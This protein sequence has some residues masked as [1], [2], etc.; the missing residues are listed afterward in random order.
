MC[1]KNGSL[2]LDRYHMRLV[3][4]DDMGYLLVSLTLEDKM[5]SEIARFLNN[6]NLFH[7]EVLLKGLSEQ[8]G[9]PCAMV[10]VLH[11]VDDGTSYKQKV[12]EEG[13]EKHS[14][15]DQFTS[16]ISFFLL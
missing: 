12:A 5:D 8:I 7:V 13:G 2:M 1:K 10:A 4:N 9:E 16:L 14:S 11:L 15:C 3:V 6:P